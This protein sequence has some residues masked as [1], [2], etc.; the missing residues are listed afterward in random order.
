MVTGIVLDHNWYT[1]KIVL[2][3][4]V[5]LNMGNKNNKN[6]KL[7]EASAGAFKCDRLQLQQIYD[8]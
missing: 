4:H 1:L 5:M 3:L 8:C 6:F 2:L 7:L